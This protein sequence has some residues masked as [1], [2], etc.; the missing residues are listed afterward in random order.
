MPE[1]LWKIRQRKK[2]T[3]AQLAAKSGVPALSI[4]EYESGKVPIRA[5]DLPRLA[6]AL[7]V[8]EEDIKL[9]SS[10]PPRKEPRKA[11]RKRKKREEMPVREGQIAHIERLLRALG[12]TRQEFESRLGRS[13]DSLTVQE[14]KDLLKLLQKQLRERR[15]QEP[16]RETQITHLL[17]LM[18]NLGLS[19]VEV[20]REIGKPLEQLT[21][22]EARQ[23]LNKYQR[24]MTA[25]R[26]P[27]DKAVDRKRAHLPEA[28]DGFECTYLTRQMED[29]ALMR[30]T[31]FDGTTFT[32]R[33]IGFGT[34]NITI[35]E[36]G[37]GE[38]VTL[39][40]LA[41]AYYRRLS[42]HQDP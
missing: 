25:R 22:F 31:L 39:Q 36:E 17:G 35:R 40:K 30:F 16:A 12:K 11:P 27:V 41:I 26:G 37:T 8:R 6:R 29:Q 2:M 42:S 28:V 34:Y 5:A 21:R 15:A 24:M 32:G 9:R 33:I 4:Q 38:Q 3:I 1:D 23:L 14:A 10:P 7:F 19:Q 13:M 20:E 18:R